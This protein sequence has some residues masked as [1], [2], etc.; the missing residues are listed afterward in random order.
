M[1]K[2]VLIVALAVAGL[3]VAGFDK[4]T[5]APVHDVLKVPPYPASPR[6]RMERNE[7][8]PIFYRPADQTGADLRDLVMQAFYEGE[9]AKDV[10]GY[11]TALVAKIQTECESAHSSGP[12]VTVE[13]GFPVAYAEVY[14]VNDAKQDADIDTFMKAIRGRDAM[15]LFAREFR[16]RPH[17]PPAHDLS[18]D[19]AV[20]RSY[21]ESIYMCPSSG[22]SGE[23]AE[24]KLRAV[25]PAGQ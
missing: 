3:A 1:R 23:C 6:W 14:C 12:R 4:E 25:H 8:G 16:R 24:D 2:I 22:G 19:Y 15:V 9:G 10:D 11:M 18:P 21:L 17:V 13:N 7:S 5:A 20:A